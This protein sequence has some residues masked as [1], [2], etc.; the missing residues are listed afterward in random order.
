MAIEKEIK[1]KYKCLYATNGGRENSEYQVLIADR[2]IRFLDFYIP[3]LKKW[4]EFDEG[5]HKYE[6]IKKDDKIKEK[7]VKKKIKGVKL[8]RIKESSFLKCEA[9]DVGIK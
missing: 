3:E 5:H 7:Q 9:E 2:F 1:N 8:L 6:K 4:I